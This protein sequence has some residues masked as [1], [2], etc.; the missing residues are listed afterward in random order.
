MS[1][2]KYTQPFKNKN[3]IYDLFLS[4]DI[5]VT[6]YHYSIPRLQTKYLLER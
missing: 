2:K 4:L 1:F 3:R 6:K 5:E